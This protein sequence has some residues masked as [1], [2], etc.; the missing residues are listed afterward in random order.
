MGLPARSALSQLAAEHLFRVGDRRVAL[1]AQHPRDLVH[2]LRFG[3]RPHLCI[4]LAVAHVLRDIVMRVRF[5]RDLRKV[6]DHDKLARSCE[7]A[8]FLRDM[9]RGHSADPHIDLVENKRLDRIDT[10]EDGLERE[11]HTGYFAARRDLP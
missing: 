2:T 4:R 3:Q 11:H 5:R 10:R 6:G 9:V 8:D 1:P 7:L